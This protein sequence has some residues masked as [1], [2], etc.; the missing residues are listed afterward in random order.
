MRTVDT[1]STDTAP[2]PTIAEIFQREI[3]ELPPLDRAPDVRR[4]IVEVQDQLASLGAQV[5]TAQAALSAH[6][7]DNSRA[8]ALALAEGKPVPTA[9][10]EPKATA[11]ELAELRRQAAAL[12]PVL[13]VLQ[14]IHRDGADEEDRAFRA[15]ALDVADDL[16]ERAMERGRRF[17]HAMLD[18]LAPYE[19]SGGRR[20][21]VVL[22][23]VTEVQTGDSPEERQ[24]VAWLREQEKVHPE[25]ARRLRLEKTTRTLTRTRISDDFVRRCVSEY[26]AKKAGGR[27]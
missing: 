2:P 6:A 5:A 4:R 14:R 8:A 15:H 24:F 20:M 11:A 3:A 23:L 17:V 16:H 19:M 22:N 21:D 12:E 13:A 25:P 1:M 7:A 10:P 9:L 27:S 18:A 26:D